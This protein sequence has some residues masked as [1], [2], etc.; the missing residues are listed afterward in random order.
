MTRININS[1]QIFIQFSPF[2]I[3]LNSTWVCQLASGHHTSIQHCA[4]CTYMYILDS[5]SKSECNIAWVGS[6]G[7]FNAGLGHNIS[8]LF[9]VPSCSSACWLPVAPSTTP[10][11]PLGRLN[12]ISRLFCWYCWPFISMTNGSGTPTTLHMMMPCF[13]TFSIGLRHTHT[14][15]PAQHSHSWFWMSL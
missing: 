7:N 12:V 13:Q 3:K 4:T 5:I 8:V 15:S 2:M 14:L 10:S 11:S 6:F 1:D 9:S